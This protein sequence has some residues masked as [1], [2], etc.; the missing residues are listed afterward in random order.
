MLTR[1]TQIELASSRLRRL[2]GAEAGEWAPALWAFAYFFFLLTAYYVLRPLRDEMGIAGGVKQLPWL[3]TGTF[4]VMLLAV[5]AFGA[6][7]TRWPRRR[8]LPAVYY[9]FIANILGFYALFA[10]GVAVPYVARAFFIWTSVF[11]LFVV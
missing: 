3:F 8:F 7:T 10:A 9:F 6:L 1:M 11:N 5:P 2:I 4:V